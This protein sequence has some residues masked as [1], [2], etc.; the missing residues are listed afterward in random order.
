[1]TA[2]LADGTEAGVRWFLE[3][4]GDMAPPLVLLTLSRWDEFG[5]RHCERLEVSAPDRGRRAWL[6][7]LIA[8][9]RERVDTAT[10]A[11]RRRRAARE[12]RA[13]RPLAGASP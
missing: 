6:L 9:F 8:A 11:Q 1:M 7:G 12:A 5:M 3:R 13:G 2:Y 4:P 10:A